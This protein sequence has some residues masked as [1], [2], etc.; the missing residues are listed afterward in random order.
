MLWGFERRAVSCRDWCA[1]NTER[2]QFREIKSQTPELLRATKQN[3]LRQEIQDIET[4]YKDTYSREFYLPPVKSTF[5]ILLR[6][7]KKNLTGSTMLQACAL[8]ERSKCACACAFTMAVNNQENWFH[9]SWVFCDIT[10]LSRANL[11]FRQGDT[12]TQVSGLRTSRQTRSDTTDC[13]VQKHQSS[14]RRCDY[15]STS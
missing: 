7:F 9:P 8:N 3:Y 6:F 4:N 15:I 13:K 14:R 10:Q 11:S 2:Q 1:H 12:W 5:L